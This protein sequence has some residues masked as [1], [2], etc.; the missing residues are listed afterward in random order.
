MGILM[1]LPQGTQDG[2][3]VREAIGRAVP[4]ER[5]EVCPTVAALA[6]RL[7]EPLDASD[8]VVLLADTPACLEELLGL[9]DLLDGARNVLL[10]PDG[11][12]ESIARG[13]RLLPRVLLY[14]GDWPERLS[15]IVRKMLE[16][17]SG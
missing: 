8:V 13:H 12:E 15:A 5:A 6:E 14:G 10:L 1:F 7:R 11:D 17:A 9:G 16:G 3:R 4:G 2:E